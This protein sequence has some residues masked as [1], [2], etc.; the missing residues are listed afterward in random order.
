MKL[1]TI[2]CPTTWHDQI[3]WIRSNCERYHDGTNWAAWQ[4][5]MDYIYFVLE[6]P[7]AMMFKLR[8]HRAN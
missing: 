1:V 3:Q 7:D 2:T 5:G 8:W 4:I 6:D